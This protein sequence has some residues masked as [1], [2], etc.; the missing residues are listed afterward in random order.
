MQEQLTRIKN[1][2]RVNRFKIIMQAA[3]SDQKVRDDFFNGLMQ[4]QN[5]ANESAVGSALSYLHHPL[6][7]HTSIH[8]LPESLEILQEIQKT[9]DIFFPD[10][11]LR[12][13]FGSYQNPKALEVVNQF[14]LKNPDYNPILKNKILQA[15][16]NLRRAQK[17][18]K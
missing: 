17:L 2:D 11:W 18:M 4:K 6:R 5:R 15:T 13:T 7:Q 10:N 12:S 1:Q 9:G 14:L 8:Y 3:S 16:D